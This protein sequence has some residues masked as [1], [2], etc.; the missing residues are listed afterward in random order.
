M[1][2]LRQYLFSLND[3]LGVTRTLGEIALCPDETGRAR[4]TVG[5]SAVN[6]HIRHQGTHKL[7]RCYLR[8]AKYLREIYGERLL[9][10]ELFLFE[11]PTSGCWVDV[12]LNDWIEGVSMQHHIEQIGPLHDVHRWQQLAEQ[13]D[14]MAAQLL[15]ETWAHGDLKP[16]N[17]LLTPTGE[18]RLIDFDAMYL[19]ALHGLPAA[20]LGTAAYQHPTRTANDFD[21][22]LDDFP[23]VLISTALHALATDPTLYDRY[24]NSDGLLINPQR[25]A[26]DAAYREILHLFAERGD[27]CAARMAHLMTSPSLRIEGLAACLTELIS[28]QKGEP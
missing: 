27:R 24:G 23:I 19:P 17:I 18:L 14:R 20:E 15:A 26:D 13:F 4:Y 6:F 25:I 21:K 2:S 5:N 1:Y 11:S 8:P 12:V 28:R 9:S 16:D 10:K 22:H 3:S 7:L